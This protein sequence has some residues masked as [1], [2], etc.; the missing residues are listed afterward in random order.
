MGAQPGPVAGRER[1]QDGEHAVRARKIIEVRGVGAAPD[2]G[3]P[4]ER[5]DRRAVGQVV[6]PGSAAV[7][8]AGLGQH[9]DPGVHRGDLLV[10]D[11]P[12]L[13]DVRAV[14]LEHHVRH[15]GQ[16]Q[17]QV[18]RLGL[19][20]VQGQAADRAVE[21]GE[22]RGGFHAG[23]LVDRVARA[24]LARGVGHRGGL[25]L[26]DVGAQLSQGRGGHRSRDDHAER[27]HLNRGQRA[28]GTRLRP[29]RRPPLGGDLGGI[30]LAE[31][32]RWAA[33]LREQR[34]PGQERLA[35]EV[36]L[37]EAG[38]WFVYEESPAPG[39]RVLGELPHCVDQRARHPELLGAADEVF[40]VHRDDRR[41]DDGHDLLGVLP[42]ARRVGVGGI[43][44]FGR[45]AEQLDEARPCLSVR[46]M[47][48]IT[49]SRQGHMPPTAG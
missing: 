20:H 40:A 11:A 32:G 26:D 9:H 3:D 23:R 36:E 19:L 29:L 12:A 31:P 15:A 21:I 44:E 49:P 16:P 14:V 46:A 22:C 6:R 27:D 38:Q 4:H 1:G 37:P 35:R 2:P 13:Q 48:S 33:V 8:E 7:P 30:M 5:E 34:L 25:D 24:K 18:D 10:A 47:N 43:A 42:P 41:R 39:L 17:H 28:G 45:A